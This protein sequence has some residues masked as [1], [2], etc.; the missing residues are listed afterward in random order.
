MVAS[1]ARRATYEDVLAA[2]RHQVAE[3]I[4]GVLYTHPRP[5]RAHTRAASRLGAELDGPF[6]RGRGGPGGWIIL[7]EPELHF[8]KG[9]HEDILVPDLAG[10]RRERMPEVGEG[11][12]FTLAPD[13]VC[14]VLSR[15]TSALDRS[16][17]MHCYAREGVSHVWLL[18]P[19]ARSLEVF[20]LATRKKTKRRTVAKGGAWVLVD[21]W[22]DDAKVRAEPFDAVPLD[23][24]SLWP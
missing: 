18:D 24:A 4:S 7:A 14:E 11:A 15:S 10:W 21:V 2:P 9:S 6:D 20:R 12:Y 16:E 23:L 17:K 8:G 3:I 13:W 19:L 5:A 22:H 1:R